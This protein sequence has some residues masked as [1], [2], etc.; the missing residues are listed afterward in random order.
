ME[1]ELMII[2]DLCPNSNP[3]ETV[4]QNGCSLSQ[5]DSDGDGVNDHLDEFPFD[6]SEA[7][8]NDGDGIGDNSDTDD[9]ND[10]VS[11]LSEILRGTDPLNYDSDYDGY[12]D[13]VD[14][15]PLDSEENLDSDNDG[16]GDNSDTDDDNDG[17]EDVD[18]AFPLDSSESQDS[19]GDGLGDNID[20]DDDGDRIIDHIDQCPY[21]PQGVSVDING[22]KIFSLPQNNYSILI[23]SLSCIGENDGS[24]SIYV[25]NQD[26]NYILR[27]N[28]E[29]PINFN[30][31]NGYQQ[32]ISSLS[33]ETYQLCFTVEGENGY[34]QCFDIVINEPPP[35]SSSSKVNESDKSMTFNLSGSDNYKII[36]NGVEQVFSIPNP[37]I[38]LNEGLNFIEVKTD[39]FCQGTYTE[40]IF[41]SERVEYYPNPTSDYVNFYIHG[42]DHSIDLIISDRNGNIL[43]NICEDIQSNRKVQ[44]NLEQYPK[45]VYIIQLTGETVIKTVK[46]IK[47]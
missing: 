25:E 6:D 10:G 32:T 30:S 41:I 31:S 2:K 27:I 22:C 14:E 15:F 29:N 43:R 39:K 5:R 11:D 40:E 26:I 45:G 28:G 18:D 35:L 23:K 12:D 46:I 33:P 7:Y 37:T 20:N 16:I 34:N 17:V 1:M 44:V 42:R 8:D 3:D 24:L 4:D 36:H 19:D 21:T 47:E 9:D 38:N 13:L